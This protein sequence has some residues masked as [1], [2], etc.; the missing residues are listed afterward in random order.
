MMEFFF[1]TTVY[2]LAVGP[3]QPPIQWVSGVL[4]SG[5]KQLGH[6]ANHS[7]PPIAEVNVWSYTS[8]SPYVF[9][10]WC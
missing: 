6:E 7:L 2:T 10:E 5:I 3:I 4:T 9:M 1:F 8:T